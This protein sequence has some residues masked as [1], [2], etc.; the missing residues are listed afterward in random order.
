MKLVG[1]EERQFWGKVFVKAMGL[2]VPHGSTIENVLVAVAR[3]ADD[4]VKLRRERG[5][6]Q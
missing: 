2:P 1:E 4:A 6:A 5:T 3:A